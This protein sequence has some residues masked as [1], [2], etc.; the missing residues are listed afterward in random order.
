MKKQITTSILI[1]IS[2]IV[3]S[4]QLTITPVN[5][6]TNNQITITKLNTNKWELKVT[7][8]TIINN[9]DTVAQAIYK[10]RRTAI[11]KSQKKLVETIKQIEPQI[12][13]NQTIIKQ[14]NETLLNAQIKTDEIITMPNNILT[15]LY[16]LELAINIET[17]ELIEI[18]INTLKIQLTP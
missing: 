14:I 9:K 3:I 7:Q 12:Q 5:H 1:I 2:V 16:K 4:A 15:G 17:K 13:H 6:P 11:A 10:A 8:Y 18:I